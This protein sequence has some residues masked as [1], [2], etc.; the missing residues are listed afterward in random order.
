MLGNVL[1]RGSCIF[2]KSLEILYSKI[3]TFTKLQNK[4]SREIGLS[5]DLAPGSILSTPQPAADIFQR[6]LSTLRG[7][8]RYPNQSTLTIKDSDI[9]RTVGKDSLASYLA[10]N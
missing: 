5:L 2:R 10:M 6:I 3:G 4:Q 7:D 9:W 1:V 8:S